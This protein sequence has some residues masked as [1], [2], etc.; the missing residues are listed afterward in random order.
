VA[1]C[2][3]YFESPLGRFLTL[4]VAKIGKIGLRR[5]NVRLR[6]RQRLH[7][8]EVID[9]R[10]QV[11]RRQDVDV[12]T[13]P[14]RFGTGGLRAD[15]ALAHRVR[16]DGGRQRA[17][18][19]ANG[20]VE[21]QLSDGCVGRNRVRRDGFH[22]RHHRQH[23]RKIEMAAFLR[24]IGRRQIDRD[25]L[26]GQAKPD[27]VQCVADALA[28]FSNGLVWQADDGERCSPRRDADLHLHGARFDTN[29]RERGNLAVHSAP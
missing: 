5:Q 4:D 2:R 23:D 9:E 27:S 15:E 25:V 1:A 12:F 14:R 21:R 6:P 7:A 26:E 17:G 13:G 29:K 11:R 16:P 22:R 10:Q 18:N 20:T 8:L 3:G 19:G 24:Q 28:A